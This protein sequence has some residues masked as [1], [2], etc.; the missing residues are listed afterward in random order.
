M[1]V[2]DEEKII[3]KKRIKKKIKRIILI[4]VIALFLLYVPGWAL[5]MSILLKTS[6][7]LPDY[8]QVVLKPD[9]A[10]FCC[11]CGNRTNIEMVFK[12]PK[13]KVDQIEKGE[14]YNSLYSLTV[15]QFF[16]K[17]YYGER[18]CT[19]VYEFYEYY[20]DDEE[21]I[22]SLYDFYTEE[23]KDC[24]FHV[25]LQVHHDLYY[26]NPLTLPLYVLNFL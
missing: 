17:E 22:Q 24:Y 21:S 6:Y 3:K 26:D 14:F 5:F 7:K 13:D 20:F 11:T 12:V 4:A 9:I 18:D 23:E 25:I 2:M 10:H 16:S 8:A 15:E 19:Y 1:N